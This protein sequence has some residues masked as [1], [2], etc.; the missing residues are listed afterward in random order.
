VH[1]YRLL[2][3]FPPKS[4]IRIRAHTSAAPIHLVAGYTLL[5]AHESKVSL[6]PNVED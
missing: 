4:D 5:L 2:R 1:Q 6:L 3:K